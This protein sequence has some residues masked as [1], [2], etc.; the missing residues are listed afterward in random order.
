M[1]LYKE[2]KYRL[3][4]SNSCTYSVQ[5]EF[6]CFVSV[7]LL[8]KGMVYLPNLYFPGEGEFG[9][10]SIVDHAVDYVACAHQ[11]PHH[12]K[13]PKVIEVF[14]FETYTFSLTDV[15]FKFFCTQYFQLCWFSVPTP[16]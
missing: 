4:V 12:F 5:M 7:P 2:I 8:A 1:S 10:R 16:M 6:F 15:H 3:T 11:H 14:I 13:P 9:Q